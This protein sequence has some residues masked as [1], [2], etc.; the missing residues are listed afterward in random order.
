MTAFVDANVV[1]Y[2][3][4]EVE[5]EL[6]A[7][8]R[9]IIRAIGEG[10]LDARTSVAVIEELLHLELRGRPPGLGGTTAEAY[11]LFTPL[12][13]VTDEIV[14]EALALDASSLGANDRVHVATCRA[15]GIATIVSTD[16][17]FDSA[18]GLQRVDPADAEAVA[19]L[20]QGD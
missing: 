13:A 16:L 20:L 12:L 10:D 5:D 7:G 1:V 3:R 14:R 19:K 9:E 11:V 6:G 2:A 8:C 17:G 15:N 18:A 4:S